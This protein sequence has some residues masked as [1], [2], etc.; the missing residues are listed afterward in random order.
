MGGSSCPPPP[1]RLRRGGLCRVVANVALPYEAAHGAGFRG[2][3]SGR[4]RKAASRFWRAGGEQ[5]ADGARRPAARQSRLRI[6]ARGP[7]A[8]RG[9]RRHPG[10]GAHPEGRPASAHRRGPR[11]AA[12]R[13]R[14]QPLDP[15]APLTLIMHKPLGLVCSHREPG[16][17]RLRTAAAALAFARSRPS[18]A[19]GGWTSTP[20][21]LLLITD[22]GDFLHRVISPRSHITKR[23]SRDPGAAADG[24]RG[25]SLRRGHAD[26][27][28]ARPRPWRRPRLERV[29][30]TEA[31]LTIT[32]GRYHQVRRMFAAVGNHVEALH[33]E[34]IG[35]LDLPADLAPGAWRRASAEG[36]RDG[37]QS[38]IRLSAP[39]TI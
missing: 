10:R 24:G 1:D 26:A 23:L 39:A 4:A 27:G 32:E 16:T 29:S 36:H 7:G 25:R 18:P 37:V 31:L 14:G 22:D 21:G 35:G 8:D 30:D 15:P 5:G 11:E 3:P 17:Q 19:S 34:R 20:P 38:L 6:A 13:V 9:R 2:R 33:R 12:S 28:R